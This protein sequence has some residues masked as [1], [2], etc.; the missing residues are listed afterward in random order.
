MQNLHYNY[1]SCN[2]V[3]P[4]T[5][6]TNE[7]YKHLKW[8]TPKSVKRHDHSAIEWT[9]RSISD[10]CQIHVALDT[11]K[12]WQPKKRNNAD[13]LSSKVETNRWQGHLLIR[14]DGNVSQQ[15]RGFLKVPN[16]CWVLRRWRPQVHTRTPTSVTVHTK[17]LSSLTLQKMS[18]W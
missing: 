17:E 16:K 4:N 12:I 15:L 2:Y 13:L 11:T 3:T 8:K 9:C 5:L 14:Q 7:D 10:R 6:T 18:F 1:V